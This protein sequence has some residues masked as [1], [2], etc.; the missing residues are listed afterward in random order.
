MNRHTTIYNTR[1][2]RIQQVFPD[3]KRVVLFTLPCP[4]RFALLQ[5][6]EDLLPLLAVADPAFSGQPSQCL[7]SEDAAFTDIF[8]QAEDVDFLDAIQS[9]YNFDGALGDSILHDLLPSIPFS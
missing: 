2:C 4:L 9:L 8:G 1:K 6:D 3:A 5:G 7:V